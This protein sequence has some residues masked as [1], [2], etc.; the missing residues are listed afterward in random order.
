M[1][2]INLLTR[3][4]THDTTQLLIFAELS[5]QFPPQLV[6]DVDT[7]RSEGCQ[8]ML[9]EAFPGRQE[10]LTRTELYHLQLETVWPADPG[11]PGCEV[12]SERTAGRLYLPAVAVVPLPQRLL[13]LAHVLL[14]TAGAGDQVDQ[15]LTGA[16]G[17][18]QERVLAAS[19]LTGEE[20][21]L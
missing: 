6:P 17:R 2:T 3:H 8:F 10:V 16:G 9:P 4:T 5:L 15:L 1:T 21:A 20:V 19:D 13:G 12:L 14:V 7:E 18:G 11:L